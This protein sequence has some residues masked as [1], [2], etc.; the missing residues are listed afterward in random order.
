MSLLFRVVYAT[1]ANGTHHKLA[2]DALQRLTRAD[3]KGWQRLFLKHVE[4]YL[5]GS[6]AP[7]KTFKDFKNHVLHVRDGYWGGAPEKVVSWYAHLVEALRQRNWTEAVWCAGVLS[8]YYTDPIHPFHTAQ[9]AA[10][11]NIHR[12]V[13]WSINRDYDAL[14]REAEVLAHTRL[15]EAPRGPDWLKDFVCQGAELANAQYERLIAHYDFNTGVVDPPAGLD[16][17]ARDLIGDLILYAADGFA[18]VIERAIAESGATPPAVALTLETVLATL[19]IPLKWVQKKLSDADDRRIVEAMYD[20]LM[21]TGRVEKA[22]PEDDRLVR[23]LHTKEVVA[24]RNA[25]QAEKRAQRLPAGSNT[26]TS[27]RSRTVARAPA[28]HAG[29]AHTDVA[30]RQSPQ[31]ITTTA[32]KERKHTPAAIATTSQAPAAARMSLVG[33]LASAS[34]ATPLPISETKTTTP[35]A[36]SSPRVYLALD[37]D[38]ERA[39]SIGPKTAER[40]YKIGIRTVAE[41]LNADALAMAEQIDARHISAE[42]V[43]DWQDQAHLVMAVPGLRGGQAQLLVGAGYHTLTAIAATDP[44]SLSADILKFAATSDGQRI[45]RDGNAPDLERIKSWIDGA[46]AALAA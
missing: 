40:F 32:N 33:S 16:P 24:A 44:V 26:A 5:E 7:D 25:R 9:S 11:N 19:K 21:E 1:H 4:L 39:P 15:V 46:S 42:A 18:R 17:I 36:Q 10:E 31:G 2:L 34:S 12:A 20:E 6:K 13:E 22:L 28:A 29:T 35:R 30:T 45:L 8:H 3:A 14:K 41:F 27:R 23:D 37:D 38:I 43:A